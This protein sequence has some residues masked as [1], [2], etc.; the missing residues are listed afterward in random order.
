MILVDSTSQNC[1]TRNAS[2]NSNPSD[3]TPFYAR[4][5]MPATNNARKPQ[6]ANGDGT[7]LHGVPWPR[8]PLE[9]TRGAMPRTAGL[10]R[11][12]ARSFQGQQRR[13]QHFRPQTPPSRDGLPLLNKGPMN[14]FWICNSIYPQLEQQQRTFVVGQ[15]LS[16]P[17][18][19]TKMLSKK[20]C[21]RCLHKQ[22]LEPQ[23]T[24]STKL[25]GE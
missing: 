9:G 23:L 4:L 16:G 12:A 2:T 10:L 3:E 17:Q 25:R 19:V 5:Q 24:S 14:W 13:R 21:N 11:Q 22:N 15:T 7:R 8:E 20:T 1:F 18:S 6:P